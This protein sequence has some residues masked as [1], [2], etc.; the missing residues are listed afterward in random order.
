[1]SAQYLLHKMLIGWS[2]LGSARG[3]CTVS[4]CAPGQGLCGQLPEIAAA[5]RSAAQPGSAGSSS[6][7]SLAT[8]GHPRAYAAGALAR[9]HHVAGTLE[10]AGGLARRPAR[11]RLPGELSSSWMQSVG[12]LLLL[13]RT[14]GPDAP[15]MQPWR[16]LRDAPRTG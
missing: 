8:V 6:P 9:D 14:L 7:G 13:D 11:P 16:E 12:Q 15:E 4:L 10:D 1:M 5:R 2:R 3:S